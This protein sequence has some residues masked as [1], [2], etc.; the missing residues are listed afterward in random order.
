MTLI[1]FSKFLTEIQ[2]KVTAI[3]DAKSADYSDT[4]DKLYNFKLQARI[5]G[6]TPVEALRGNLRK[7]LASVI[8]GLDEIQKGKVRPK[9]W[10]W[11]KTIDLINY[12]ILLLALLE[13]EYY[14]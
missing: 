9:E 4:K 14:A 11:E 12:Y 10:F 5:D 6:T 13:D 1:D 3:L 8:Q 7:H 2:N